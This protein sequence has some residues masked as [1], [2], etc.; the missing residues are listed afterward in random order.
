MDCNLKKRTEAVLKL[1]TQDK[2][3]NDEYLKSAA[4]SLAKKCSEY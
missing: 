3:D 2:G 1:T 4:K